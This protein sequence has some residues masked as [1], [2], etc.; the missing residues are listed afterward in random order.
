MRR[1]DSPG[2]SATSGSCIPRPPC[3]AWAGIAD[4][5]ELDGLAAEIAEVSG[6]RIVVGDM[7][8]TDASP[9]FADFLRTTR[10]RDSRL[11]FGRQ[12]SWPSWSPYRIAIDHAFLSNDLAVVRRKLLPPNGSDHFALLVELAPAAAMAASTGSTSSAASSP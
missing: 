7:N 11:G 4:F 6:S 9:H 8:T 5:A 1:S 2:R 10:L 12:A 3:D